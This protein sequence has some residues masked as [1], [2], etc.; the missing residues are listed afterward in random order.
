MLS[1]AICILFVLLPLLSVRSQ[2]FAQEDTTTLHPKRK[3]IR[4]AGELVF[5][6][7]LPWS[8]NRFVRKAEFAKVDFSSIGKNLQLSNWEWDDN[9][10]NTNQFAHPYHGNLYYNSFRSNG[11]SFWQSAPAAFAGS[12]LWEVAGETHKA[13]PNDFINTSLGG[14]SLGE[15]THRLSDKIVNNRARGLKRQFQEVMGLLVNPMNGL[16]RIMNGEWGRVLMQG[17]AE[18]SEILTTYLNVGS[19]HFDIHSL[20]EHIHGNNEFY[21]RLRLQYGDRFKPSNIPFQSFSAQ[22]EAGAND[23]AY[24][25]TVQVNGALKTWRLREDSSQVHLYSVTMNYDFIKNNAFEYGG[26]SFTLKVLSDWA[27][28]R[29]TKIYTEIGSGIIVLGA[30]PD[31]YLYYGEGRNYDYGPG[32]QVT[33]STLI[34]FHGRLETAFNY[35]GSRFQTVNGSKSSYILNT[36]SADLRV[37]VT[38]HLLLAAGVGQFTLNGFYKG[39]DNISETY[40]FAHLSVGCKF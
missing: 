15:M 7:L 12:F 28:H 16:N 35:K 10:F 18:N 21:F 17:R 39:K 5:T 38:Q 14:I 19:R 2:T 9:N 32:I 23:S 6:E 24:I 27:K 33:A 22:V 30:V 20:K 40:P 25:N 8:Y 3:F 13:A 4:A 1:R 37:Y 11:Y 31:K 29:K 36:L 34:D 26:Q